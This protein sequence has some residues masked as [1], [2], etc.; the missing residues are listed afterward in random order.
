MRLASFQRPHCFPRGPRS[1]QNIHLMFGRV[2]NYPLQSLF[3]A[4]HIPHILTSLAP[5]IQ[6]RDI[7]CISPSWCATSPRLPPH[8]LQFEGL[9]DGWWDV[10]WGYSHP[11]VA[12]VTPQ[13]TEIEDGKVLRCCCCDCCVV[14]QP[15]TASVL[16]KL[17]SAELCSHSGPFI[18]TMRLFS[19]GLEC[20]PSRTIPTPP[21]SKEGK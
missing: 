7:S 5:G 11:D 21:R 6:V 18:Q 10:S 14:N 2:H 16:F 8:L 20:L 4:C 3:W 1:S 12:T 9:S 15:T 17:C 19:D 13:P